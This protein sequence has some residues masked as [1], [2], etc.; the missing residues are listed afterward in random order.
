MPWGV[1]SAAAECGVSFAEAARHLANFRGV[2]RRFEPIAQVGDILV[3]DDYAHHPTEIAATLQAARE[4][5]GRRI[6]AVFQP[7]RYSRARFFGMSLDLPSK[8][9]M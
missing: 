2:G 1:L 3:F 5:W 8:K 7:H 6:V 4:G 9:P